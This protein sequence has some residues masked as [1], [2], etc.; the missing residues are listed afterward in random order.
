GR[1]VLEAWRISEV[2][3]D[4][5]AL[6]GVGDTHAGN[7]VDARIRRCRQHVVSSPAQPLHRF[8]SD[9]SGAPDDDDLHAQSPALRVEDW[10]ARS[11][12]SGMVMS[13]TNASR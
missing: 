2:D 11:M 7:G 9:E 10:V 1:L 4:V 8:R 6:Q 3:D 13:A 12:T 5:R